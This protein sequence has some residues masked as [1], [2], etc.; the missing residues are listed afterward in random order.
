MDID[1]DEIVF[2]DSVWCCVIPNSPASETMF[3]HFPAEVE[4][5]NVDDVSELHLK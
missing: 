2:K 5:D 1:E 3:T 4:E